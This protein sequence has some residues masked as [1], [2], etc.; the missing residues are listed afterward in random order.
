MKYE[1]TSIVPLCYADMR[2]FLMAV[3]ADTALRAGLAYDSAKKR[4]FVASVT[5]SSVTCTV[6]FFGV[7]VMD[8]ADGCAPSPLPPLMREG[9]EHPISALPNEVA[10]YYLLSN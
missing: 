3:M 9:T 7:K 4:V 2:T 10:L 6:F 1:T 8:T 5:E